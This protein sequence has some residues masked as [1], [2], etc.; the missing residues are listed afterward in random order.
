MDYLKEIES[1]VTDL[2]VDNSDAAAELR[3]IYDYSFSGTELL[4]KCVQFLLS[5]KEQVNPSIKLRILELKI[6]CNSIGLFPSDD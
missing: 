1:I 3:E 5:I 6:F 4:M 2:K